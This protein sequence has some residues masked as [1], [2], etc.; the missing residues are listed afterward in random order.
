MKWYRPVSR[1]KWV[2][3]FFLNFCSRWRS[4]ANWGG[5]G[6]LFCFEQTLSRSSLFHELARKPL[7]CNHSLSDS[8]KRFL[9]YY[10][11]ACPREP[12]HLKPCLDGNLQSGYTRDSFLKVWSRD[13]TGHKSLVAFVKNADSWAPFQTHRC[14]GSGN[15]RFNPM[16]F[17]W[18]LKCEDHW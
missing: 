11:L 10:L 15:L 13:K 4:F 16:W 1:N 8:G 14:W 2:P 7:T 12:W 18:I 3:F 6:G 17:W 9:I 5:G